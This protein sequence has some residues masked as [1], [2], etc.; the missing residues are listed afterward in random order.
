MA[1]T[2][3]CCSSHAGIAADFER[4][5]A[6][7]SRFAAAIGQTFRQTPG[8]TYHQRGSSGTTM[9]QTATRAISAP[10]QSAAATARVAPT[11][12]RRTTGLT[13]AGRGM[14]RWTLLRGGRSDM[15]EG[16]AALVGR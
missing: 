1:T 7:G 13:S 3:P 5:I 15:G 8:A 10:F 11:E 14:D 16:L 4:P 2:Y 12:A 6:C 9:L